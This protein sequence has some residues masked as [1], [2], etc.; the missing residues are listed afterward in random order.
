MGRWDQPGG[1]G[2]NANFF[3]LPLLKSPLC[4]R[5]SPPRIPLHPPPPSSC[6]GRVSTL[7]LKSLN[8]K[9][10]AFSLQSSV[11]SLQSPVSSSL[12]FSVF[13]LRSSVFGLRSSPAQSSPVQSSVQTPSPGPPVFVFFSLSR[14]RTSNHGCTRHL[15]LGADQTCR[16]QSRL[17]HRRLPNAALQVHRQA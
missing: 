6:L 17:P 15:P 13:G 7:T 8:I 3:L 2:T 9:S 11:F 14:T 5:L 10:S 16:R 12:R 1:S 4:H